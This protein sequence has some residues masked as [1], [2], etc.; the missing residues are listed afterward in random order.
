[1]CFWKHLLVYECVYEKTAQLVIQLKSPISL[2]L[3]TN[4]VFGACMIMS[5]K[6]FIPSNLEE[7]PTN[8]IIWHLFIHIGIVFKTNV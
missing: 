4:V 6:H 5:S 2:K 7:P 1:M 3:S 8:V